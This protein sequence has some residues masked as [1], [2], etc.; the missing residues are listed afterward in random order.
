M[1][2]DKFMIEGFEPI[3]MWVENIGPFRDRFKLDFTDGNGDPCNFFLLISENGQGKTTLLDVMVSL[4]SMLQE[5]QLDSFNHEDL[6]SVGGASRND[7]ARAQLDIL[8][9]FYQNGEHQIVILSLIA[10]PEGTSSIRPWTESELKKAGA[11]SWSRF[12]YKRHPSGRMERIGGKD[13]FV[14]DLLSSIQNEMSESPDGFGDSVVS[15]PTILYFTAYRDIPKV[16]DNGRS[17]S[18]PED[19]TYRAVKQ[20]LSRDKWIHSLDNLLVWLKWIDD[21]R[22]ER[23]IED[24]NRW[25]FKGTSKRLVGVQK[26][27]PEA[28]IS[29][30]GA[31]HRL[32]R[33]SSG[34]KS[35]TQM[36]LRIGAHMTRNTWIVID[37]IDVHLHPKW[38]HRVLNILKQIVV[39]T[40]GITVIASTHSREILEGFEFEIKEA[41]LKK[42]G[43]II[44]ENL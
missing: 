31:N 39:E 8:V 5:D 20:F 17:I 32:D 22:F 24:V 30:K 9:R 12:G 27:P 33:L 38:Q 14:E 23:A 3:R 21:N 43:H 34:E 15:V 36:M 4:M 13:T 28:I 19:W 18:A 25:I 26:D 16:V 1:P 10:G 7:P 44:E 35:L 40:P 29:N 2:I 11:V 37:E 42:G 6:D 41:G